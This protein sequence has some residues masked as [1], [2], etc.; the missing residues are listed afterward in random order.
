MISLTSF[1]CKG[2]LGIKSDS[3]IIMMEFSWYD[4]SDSHSMWNTANLGGPAT[5]NV[6]VSKGFGGLR[7]QGVKLV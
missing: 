3:R 5:K 1:K 4:M 6:L 2:N 7:V